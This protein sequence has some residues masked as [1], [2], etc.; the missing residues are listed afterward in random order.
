MHE[1]TISDV[2]SIMA[3]GNYGVCYEPIINI[4][5]MEIFAYEAL[6]RFRY[7]NKNISPAVFFKCIHENIDLFFVIESTLKKFQ[8]KHSIQDKNL[9]LNLD[10]DTCISERQ[11]EFWIDLLQNKTNVTIEIIENSDE[12]SIEHTKN[13]IEWLDMYNIPFAYDDF[14]KPNSIFFAFLLNQSSFIKLD[15]HFLRTIRTNESYLAILIGVVK[16]ANKNNQFTILE[17]VETKEDL[18]VAQEAG[19]D[20]IQGYLF[21]D[22]FIN[23]WNQEHSTYI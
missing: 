4:K 19:V 2:S 9:F 21:K 8:L 7:K 17:G 6:S 10:P 15:I 20:Y 18:K 22:K 5:T 12:E 23:V 1:L 11:V 13:F 3:S 14:G 16:Y